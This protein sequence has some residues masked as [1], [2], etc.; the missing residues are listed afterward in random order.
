M[1]DEPAITPPGWLSAAVQTYLRVY[2]RHE[3]R[4]DAPVPDGPVLFVCNHGFGGVID[5]NVAAF[6]AARQAAGVTRPVTAMVHQIAWTLGAGSVVERL[7]GAP[8]SRAAADEAL[9]A[10]H[11]VLVFP[12]GDVDAGKSWR[13]RNRITFHG[14]G[15]ARLAQDHGVPMVPVVTAGAGESLLVL[16]DGQS[17]ARALRLPKLLRIKSLPVSV[18]IPWGLNLGVV[19]LVPYLPLPTKLVTAVM[20]GMVSQDQESDE[21]LAERVRDAMQTRIDALTAGR[22]P[23]IG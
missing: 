18:S 2:H 14:S 23:V 11:D 20:P 19:G 12:G 15:F 8:A 13:H 5:L 7:G 22:T 6:V 1:S 4:I 21:D 16:N 3:V 10:G 9:T 17:T